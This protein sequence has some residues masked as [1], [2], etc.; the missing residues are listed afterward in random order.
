MDAH[1]DG[2]ERLHREECESLAPEV[3]VQAVHVLVDFLEHELAL[4]L[5][6]R[7]RGEGGCESDADQ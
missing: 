3:R 4:G 6:D 2:E 5:V 1:Q 7:H